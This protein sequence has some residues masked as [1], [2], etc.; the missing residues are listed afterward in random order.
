MKLNHQHATLPKSKVVVIGGGTGTSVVLTGLK[1]HSLDLT[2]IIAVADSGGSTGRLRDE[3]G[4]QPVGDLR[5][6]LAALAQENGQAWIQQVLLYRF[7]QG[8]SLKGHNL[9]NLILTALQDLTGSTAK[10][11]EKASKIFRLEGH[12]YPATT[13]NVDL[14]VEYTDGTFLIGEHHLNPENVGGKQIKRIRL[15]PQAKMYSKAKESIESADLIVIG[16]GDLYASILPNLVVSGAKQ[17]FVKSKATVV[18]VV[19]LMTRFTQTH[20]FKASDHVEE[21]KKYLG[22][23]PDWVIVNTANIPSSLQKSYKKDHEFPVENDLKQTHYQVVGAPL[24]T[25]AKTVASKADALKRSLLRHDETKLTKLL[26][27]ILNQKEK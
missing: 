12:I 19:N 4:F 27:N 17:S 26:I 23:Y 7:S 14:V 5:Q 10:A 16:P 20:G 24:V 13:T 2:A 21:I 15:S 25:I 6:S 22:R 18:Y 3:F 11:V 9:G 1:G 8:S